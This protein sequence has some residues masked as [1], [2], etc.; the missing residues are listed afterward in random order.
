MYMYTCTIQRNANYVYVCAYV[1]ASYRM[2]PNMPPIRP[3]T[4]PQNAPK[5][6]LRPSGPKTSIRPH[7]PREAKLGPADGAEAMRFFSFQV[8]RPMDLQLGQSS[9]ILVPQQSALIAGGGGGTEHFGSQKVN[10]CLCVSGCACVCVCA[11]VH[12][13]APKAPRR[14]HAP[15]RPQDA[16][17]HKMHL[18]P[19]SVPDAQR[20]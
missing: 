8:G 3:K 20:I 11:R 6:Q 16:Q 9:E 2:C 19:Q 10:V 18:R 7:R 4:R 13:D 14:T 12:Q 1:Y 15:L 5:A 17:G